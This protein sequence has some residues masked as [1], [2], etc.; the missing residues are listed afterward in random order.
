[1]KR[2]LISMMLSIAS[3][4]YA[5]AADLPQPPPQAPVA[6]VPV[7]VPVY[8]WAGI[9]IGVNGGYGFGNSD[10][11][12]GATSSGNF[13]IN[14]FLIGGTVGVNFQWDAFVLGAE[15]DLDYAPV[16]G[17]GPNTFCINCQ[18]SSTWLGTTRVRAGYA[19]DR[20]L[21]YGTAGVAY[22]DVVASAFNT[23]NS[24]TE[25]G[26]TAGAG[27][28]A[29][30]TD[31]WTARLEYLYVDLSQGSCTTA[32]GGSPAQSVSF[33]ENLLRGGLDFKFRP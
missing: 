29:A 26:W 20:V 2:I 3:A 11:T 17:N 4:G 24:S 25:V 14:G 23:T 10:W 13:D 6:Y 32:C 18:T 27:V 9:Y 1:M 21:F 8:N 16:S 33:Q 30:F 15:T 12:G 28:E 22:G 7:M 19:A 31:N 5:L